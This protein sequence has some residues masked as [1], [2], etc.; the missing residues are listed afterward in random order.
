MTEAK[1]IEYLYLSNKEILS[2]LQ[3]TYYLLIKEKVSAEAHP[4]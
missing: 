3:N 2:V 4:R 1:F